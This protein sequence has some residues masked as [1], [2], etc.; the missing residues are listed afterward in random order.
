MKKFKKIHKKYYVRKSINKKDLTPS[1]KIKQ[2]IEP[3]K[4]IT[5]EIL[6]KKHRKPKKKKLLSDKMYFTQDTE[7]SIVIYNSTEDDQVRNDLYNNKIKYAFEKLVENIFNTFKFSYFETGP[8]DVQKET[9]S[10][11]V[12]NIGKF[13]VGKGKAF[14]YFSIIAKNYLIALNNSTYK[15]FNQ[16]VEIGEEKDEHT[17]QLQSEDKHYKEKELQ[18]FMRLMILFWENN[19]NKIFTKQRD[20]DIANA[21]VELFRQTQNLTMF[22]KKAL[23]LYIRDIS[24][25][26]TQMITKIINRMKV[27][28]SK[29]Y[30]SYINYG[31][32]PTNL[33]DISK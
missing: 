19:V 25:C 22:N 15:R 23:Y 27:F 4:L 14:S 5:P 20:L 18:D 30:K 11:L 1:K 9:V 33:Y 21:I 17:I 29:I 8:L 10:H 13:E 3:I 28:Q 7:D 2:I 24:N 6:P 16:H 12:A 26:K 31:T 32:V